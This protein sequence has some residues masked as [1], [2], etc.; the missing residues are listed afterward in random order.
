MKVA[1]L[2]SGGDAPGM[3]AAIRAV[4]RGCLYKGMEV[5]GVYQ[6]Y[7]GLINDKIEKLKV[8]SV[9]DIIHRGGTIL[10]TARSDEFQTE[11]GR[12]IAENNLRKRGIDVL[13]VIG[14][15][16][17]LTGGLAF[18]KQTGI[19]VYGL[20][21]TI[22]NDLGYTDSTIGF[23]TAVNTAVSAIGNIRDTSSSM[24]RTTI[25]EV[26]GRHCGDIALYAGLAGGAETI[27]IPEMPYD[28]DKIA[29]DTAAGMK[30]GKLHSIIVKAEG[31]DI[32][33][34][35]LADILEQ[36][37]GCSTKTVLL[38]YIQRGG[39]PT[40]GDR[41]LASRLG[42]RVSELIEANAPSCAVGIR[43]DD[44]VDYPIEE[45]LNMEKKSHADFM[46]ICSALL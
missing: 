45:A 33:T 32:P 23:D 44:I 10:R 36:K 42:Y 2:T 8:S 25:I 35:E 27:L 6:G 15:D 1:I 41:I 30:R 16:G 17:T 31:V 20:P 5:Y 22:D 14:G 4:V 21:G 11:E 3:N 9:A 29:H 46:E 39:H 34:Q 13:V 38:G 28:I 18:T 43:G 19:R 24:G 12:S 26:M 7:D 40:A 37:T